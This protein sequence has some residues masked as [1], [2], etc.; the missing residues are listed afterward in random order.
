M[1]LTSPFTFWGPNIFRR[2]RE[3]DKQDCKNLDISW[4]FILP[5]SRISYTIESLGEK[6][7]KNVSGKRILITGAAMGMGRIY[8]KLSANENASAIVL[9]DRD[10]KGLQES[11]KELSDFEGKLLLHTLDLSDP[12]RILESLNLV[13]KEIGSIDILINNAGIVCG[14]YFWEHDPD[15]EIGSVISINALAPMLLTRYLLPDMM[16]DPSRDFRI[17]N[18]ASAAG[19]ISNPKMSVYCASKWALTGWSDS[20]RLELEKTGNDHIKVTTV[21]PAYISTGMFE[22]VKGMLFTPIL[23]PEYV[24]SKVWKAMKKGSPRLILPWT[25]YLSCFLKG[26]LP[27]RVF[28]WIAGNVFGVYETMEKFKGRTGQILKKVD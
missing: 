19:L 21:N 26:L 27:I 6:N 24:V 3:R 16:G 7:M 2:K 9:W 4:N 10:P 14:K 28:D 13:R 18:I 1:E 22:G 12:K 5:P 17:V 11:A 25:V 23:S 8:A 15:S 20:L